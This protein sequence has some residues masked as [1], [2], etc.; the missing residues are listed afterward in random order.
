M[1]PDD[2][3]SYLK[4]TLRREMLARRFSAAQNRPDAPQK[5]RDVFLAGVSLPPGSLVASYCPCRGEIDPAPLVAALVNA[6]HRVCL[7]CIVRGQSVLAFR[8]WSPG[9]LLVPGPLGSIPEPS[10]TASSVAP[11]ILLVPLLAFDR[12]GQR[13]GYGGGYY[14]RTLALLRKQRRI[15][16][17]GLGF[18]SQEVAAVPVSDNDQPLDA[19]ATDSGVF[20]P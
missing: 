5:L 20:W 12:R 7:P 1:P 13:L 15:L 11:S 9:C 2:D 14:D 18:S 4:K 16:A 10:G 3:L 17:V 6:K 8:E 19:V